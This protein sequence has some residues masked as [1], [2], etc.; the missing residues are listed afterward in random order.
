M[1]FLDE[2]IAGDIFT[3]IFMMLFQ[4]RFNTMHGGLI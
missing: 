4:V 3:G 1:K 2:D